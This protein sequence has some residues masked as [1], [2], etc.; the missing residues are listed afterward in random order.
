V[1]DWFATRG[2]DYQPVTVPIAWTAT[3]LLV[4]HQETYSYADVFTSTCGGSGFYLIRP[5]A[6]PQTISQGEP[7]CG[8]LRHDGNVAVDPTARSVVYSV[9]MEPNNSGLV[10]LDVQTGRADTLNTGCAV[11]LEHPSVSPDGAS[12]AA[13]GLCEGRD[14]ESYS[15]YVMRADGSGLREVAKEVAED[16]AAWSADGRWLA[17]VDNSREPEIRLSITPSAGGTPR[18]I[19]S[20]GNPA[21]S[22]DGRWIA[23]VDMGSSADEQSLFLVRA[24][25]SGRRVLYRNDARGTFS[26][27]WG[28]MRE[29]VPSGPLVWSADSRSIAFPRRF[30]RGTSVWTVDFESGRVHQLTQPDR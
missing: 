5:A 7:A 12:I 20:G 27:G 19:T 25:G 24:D 13:V 23:F 26:K 10:R 17:F 15:L 1:K 6:P 29:G 22:P 14:Q 28:P 8:A 3:G 11:Y 4:A 16:P 18:A 30:R 9:W 2:M 21:W